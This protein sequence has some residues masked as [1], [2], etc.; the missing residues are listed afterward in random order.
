MSGRLIGLEKY[1][2]FRPVGVGETWRRMLEKCVLVVTGEEAKEAC[3]TEQ[4]YS[5]LYAGIEGGIHAVQL[6]WNKHAQ[7]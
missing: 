5:G 6:L 4:L 3:G 2:G 1:P 7:R